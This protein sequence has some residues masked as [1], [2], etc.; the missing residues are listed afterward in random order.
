M[1]FDGLSA[2][3]RVMWANSGDSAVHGLL[4]IRPIG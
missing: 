1:R 4:L 3:A 2:A